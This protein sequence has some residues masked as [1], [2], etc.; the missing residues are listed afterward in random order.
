[1]ALNIKWALDK[2]TLHNRRCQTSVIPFY[3]DFRRQK[4][5]SKVYL[6][7]WEA[8]A[9]PTLFS[10]SLDI[11][12]WKMCKRIGLILRG[13]D[14]CKS[15]TGRPQNA[16][17]PPTTQKKAINLVDWTLAYSKCFTTRSSKLFRNFT[18]IA[19]W[20]KSKRFPS[21]V[22]RMRLNFILMQTRVTYMLTS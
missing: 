12:S 10:K 3:A 21:N 17:T 2:C 8:I 15:R 22:L 6:S 4:P 16:M 5:R 7:V 14:Y 1:M 18:W 9:E 19:T 13:G 11:I 20:K